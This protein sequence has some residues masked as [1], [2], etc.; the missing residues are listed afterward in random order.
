VANRVTSSALR[1]RFAAF[2]W[3][4]QTILVWAGT[5]VISTFGFVWAGAV[6]GPSYWYP[7]AKPT[8]FDFLNIWDVEWYH[9]IFD[10]GLG[11]AP[12]YQIPLP[13]NESGGVTQNAWA[14]MPGFPM[15]V[16]ALT[17]LTGGVIPWK[18]L[19]PTTS[20]IL[21]FVLALAIFKVF[22]LKFETATA[23]WG[24]AIFGLW[25]ASPILQTGYAE[26]LGFLFL[27]GGLYFLMQHRYLASVP[28]LI[29]LSLTRPGMVSF[30]L[31]LAGMWAVRAV[32]SH[33][34]KTTGEPGHDFPT[35][36][37]WKLAAL[38]ITAGVLGLLWPII[39][40]LAT[41]RIDAYTATELAWRSSNPH[42]QLQLMDRWLGLFAAMYGP[43]FGIIALA[44]II[45]GVVSI[46]FTPTVKLLG[47]ELR[48][49]VGSY[50]LYLLLVF[51]P[52]SSTFRILMPAFPL[53]AALAFKSK[54]WPKWLKAS[55]VGVLILTQFAWLTVCWVY[56]EPDFT[57]P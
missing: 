12:G 48:L 26:T 31:S 41:G 21:S 52:Q 10:F 24:V 39:A 37:R 32:K 1:G 4:L 9:R 56:V 11:Q 14:F 38:T 7:W 20:L 25:C 29:G 54:D 49:W 33:R 27:A 57:P 28:F 13:L 30:A 16:R 15:L 50:F 6:Q 5:R 36:E 42:A 18:I 34:A 19:A 45:A 35:A 43:V 51:N 17:W 46:M 44:V 3:W 53:A 47:N 23:L 40:W 8:Y 22:S 55:M 2:P